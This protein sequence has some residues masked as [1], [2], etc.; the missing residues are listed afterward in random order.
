[1]KSLCCKAPTKLGGIGDFHDA[2]TV[3]TTYNVCT[4]C[5]QPCDLLPRETATSVKSE[6]SRGKK[7]ESWEEEFESLFHYK[8][9]GA[10]SHTIAV[11]ADD[12]DCDLITGYNDNAYAVPD[13]FKDFIHHQKEISFREGLE[14]AIEESQRCWTDLTGIDKADHVI[15]TSAIRKQLTA[16][17]QQ[18]IQ[19][20]EKTI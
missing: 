16:S 6:E 7:P 14:R 15:L 1:M 10:W 3:C 17:L 9:E 5:N 20:D 18:L 13:A 8:G 4:A 11:C 19:P 2:D 12:D